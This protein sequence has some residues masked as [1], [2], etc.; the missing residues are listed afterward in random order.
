MNSSKVSAEQAE[1][2]RQ[3]VGD[4]LG[5]PVCDVIRDGPD[6]LVDVVINFK[7]REEWVT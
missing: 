1:A 3:R 2:E 4:E 7:E 6:A 5:L